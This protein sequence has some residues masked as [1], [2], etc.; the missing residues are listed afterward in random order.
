MATGRAA[1]WWRRCVRE[2]GGDPT[3]QSELT[4]AQNYWFKCPDCNYDWTTWLAPS[5]VF[6][7]LSFVTDQCPNC[8]R[9][10]VPAYTVE[11]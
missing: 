9:K 7:S 8:H 11:P 4:L 3:E 6:V 10:N 5:I 1:D 2:T